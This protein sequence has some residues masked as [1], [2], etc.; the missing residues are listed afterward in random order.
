MEG[1]ERKKCIETYRNQ[2]KKELTDVDGR[3]KELKEM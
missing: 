2:L 1:T 3:V